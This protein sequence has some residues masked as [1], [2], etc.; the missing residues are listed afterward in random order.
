MCCARIL[1]TKSMRTCSVGFGGN[2][3]VER[4]LRCNSAVCLE[5]ANCLAQWKVRHCT[6][7]D[8]WKVFVNDT[9][10][11]RGAL[12]CFVILPLTLTKAMKAFVFEL[13]ELGK[14]PRLILAT[15][16][17]RPNIPAP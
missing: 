9:P 6:G 15:M 7:H 1:N 3:M 14:P 8:K 12:L 4:R 2:V 17:K 16:N 11:A 10:H 13:D 5:T